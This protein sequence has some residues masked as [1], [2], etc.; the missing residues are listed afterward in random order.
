MADVDI[1]ECFKKHFRIILSHLS[2]SSKKVILK[3]LDSN[4]LSAISH[5]QSSQPTKDISDATEINFTLAF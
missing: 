2:E 3:K 5:N 4:M 1:K